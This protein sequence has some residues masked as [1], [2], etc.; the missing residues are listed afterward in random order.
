MILQIK[1]IGRNKWDG[2]TRVIA[3][4]GSGWTYEGGINKNI[5][6][7]INDREITYFKADIGTGG[8]IELGDETTESEYNK[9]I[10]QK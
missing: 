8:I 4:D 5:D 2:S 7:A 3:T 6:D 9:W 10:K 1:I